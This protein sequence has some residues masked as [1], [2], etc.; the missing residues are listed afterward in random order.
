MKMIYFGLMVGDGFVVCRVVFKF[1]CYRKCI[2]IIESVFWS[3][4]WMDI[5]V[6]GIFWFL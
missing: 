6:F 3:V 2:D 4:L 1:W 5:V